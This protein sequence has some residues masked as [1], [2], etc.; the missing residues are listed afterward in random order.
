MLITGPAPLERGEG[1]EAGSQL[2]TTD[3]G[4]NRPPPAHRRE[5]EPLGPEDGEAGALRMLGLLVWAYCGTPFDNHGGSK[6]RERVAQHCAPFLHVLP[7]AG[8]EVE[9]A[10]EPSCT[11]G[12]PLR[13]LA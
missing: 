8:N 9:G 4:T 1:G 12:R 13:V 11:A 6:T 7:G 5:E 10:P 3:I 2:A